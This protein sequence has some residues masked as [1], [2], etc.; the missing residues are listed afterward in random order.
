MDRFPFLIAIPQLKPRSMNC[1]SITDG[2]QC[3]LV[4][5]PRDGFRALN[6]NFLRLAGCHDC[7]RTLDDVEHL[8]ANLLGSFLIDAGLLF[9]SIADFRV[10]VGQRKARNCARNDRASFIG[11]IADQDGRK[12]TLRIRRV[13]IPLAKHIERWLPRLKLDAINGVFPIGVLAQLDPL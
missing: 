2:N 1:A 3:E 7:A 10:L 6:Y 12:S 4:F 11:L 8:R 13:G 9:R 5:G